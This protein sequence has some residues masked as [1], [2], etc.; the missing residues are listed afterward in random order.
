MSALIA[1]F[2]LLHAVFSVAALVQK[3]IPKPEGSP[4]PRKPNN[5]WLRDGVLPRQG[6]AAGFPGDPHSGHR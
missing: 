5:P 4:A 3:F 2:L 1:F 6:G